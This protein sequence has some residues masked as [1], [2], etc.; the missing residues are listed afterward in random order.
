MKEVCQPGMDGV[1]PSWCIEYEITKE[2][3][4]Q[5]TGEC[6]LLLLLFLA[7]YWFFSWRNKKNMKPIK[8]PEFPPKSKNKDTL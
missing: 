6:F 3:A 5:L 4:I 1:L 7:S 8:E 2:N